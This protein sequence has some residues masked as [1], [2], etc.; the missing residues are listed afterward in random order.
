MSIYTPKLCPPRGCYL[1]ARSQG[2]VPFHGLGGALYILTYVG[3][4]VTADGVDMVP[5]FEVPERMGLAWREGGTDSLQLH[6]IGEYEED[7]FH[8]WVG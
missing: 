5:R 2:L 3:Q 4:G 6:V 8:W 7:S 1:P